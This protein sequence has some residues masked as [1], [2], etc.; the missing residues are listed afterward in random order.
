MAHV[1]GVRW[2]LWE[3]QRLAD[4]IG[5][6][7]QAFPSLVNKNETMSRVRTLYRALAWEIDQYGSDYRAFAADWTLLRV[8][9]PLQVRLATEQLLWQRG[10]PWRRLVTGFRP[11]DLGGAE[12]SA[13]GTSPP[14]GSDTSPQVRMDVPRPQR[15]EVP[16]GVRRAGYGRGYRRTGGRKARK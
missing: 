15:Y 6:L 13:V 3:L 9:V 1:R 4:R 14:G 11:V 7:Y 12:V 10:E 2:N 16:T 8:F 5:S